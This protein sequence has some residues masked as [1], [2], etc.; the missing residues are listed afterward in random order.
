MRPSSA[1]WAHGEGG[2]SGCLLQPSSL[3][4]PQC[5]SPWWTQ[6]LLCTLPSLPRLLLCSQPQ[7]SPRICPLKPKLQH[8]V[9][10][11]SAGLRLGLGITGTFCDDFSLSCLPSGCCFLLGAS[12]APS[13]P[14]DL[15]TAAGLPRGRAIFLL[16]R[17]RSFPLPRGGGPVPVS[18]FF[19]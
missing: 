8:P 5:S 11:H 15:P 13:V 9:P 10:A 3:C 14:D 19:F 12:K 16:G 2:C 1:L 6:A 18:F 4:S 7:V 17:S